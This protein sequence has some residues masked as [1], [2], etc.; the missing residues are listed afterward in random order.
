MAVITISRQLGSLGCDIA[1][2]VADSL[3]HRL[4][5]RDLINQAARRAGT[6]EVALETIDELGLLQIRASAK[7]RRAYRAAMQMVMEELAGEGKVVIVGRAGQLIL[8]DWPDTV[9]IRL[10]APVSIRAAR[11]A[12]RQN[13]AM[14]S[15]LAQVQTSDRYRSSYLRRFYQARWDNPELYD[16][17]INT[18]HLTVREAARLICEAVPHYSRN[19]LTDPSLLSQEPTLECQ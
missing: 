4:L 17:V 16:L 18:A 15:A 10:I 3:G 14:D 8:K 5:W 12:Q 9:H 11:V 13:I 2:Q 7:A 19:S 1:Q 6:P